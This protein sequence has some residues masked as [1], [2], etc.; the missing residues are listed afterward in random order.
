MSSRWAA[1]LLVLAAGRAA[2]AAEA[3]PTAVTPLAPSVSSAPVVSDRRAILGPVA[4]AVTAAAPF[5]AG[6]VLWAQNDHRALQTTGT[7]VMLSGFALAPWV[8]HGVQ[9]RWR[10]AAV[11]GAISTATAAAT[12]VYMEHRDPFEPSYRNIERVPFGMLL[13]AAL[14][15][16]AA[17]VVDSFLVAPP[18]REAP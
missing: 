1:A 15:A 2:A 12:V 11:F 8:A 9:G 18:R 5:V 3:E 10:R 16:S 14:F 17:G 7:F 6:C 4:G 13:T